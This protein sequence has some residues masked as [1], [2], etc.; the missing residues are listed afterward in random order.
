MLLAPNVTDHSY[1]D[2]VYLKIFTALFS[3]KLKTFVF[4][5]CSVDCFDVKNILRS[6][7]HG[8]T[9]TGSYM[10]LADTLVGCLVGWLFWV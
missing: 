9:E 6:A 8:S 1:F 5:Q 7:T 2:S 3:G 10:G 4:C